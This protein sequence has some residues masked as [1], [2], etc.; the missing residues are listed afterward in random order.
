MRTIRRTLVGLLA[1]L[2][3]V[4]GLVSQAGAYLLGFTSPDEGAGLAAEAATAEGL[5]HA[6][7]GP[8]AVG[9]RRFEEAP[10]TTTAWYPA[11]HNA[12]EGAPTTYSYG[13]TVAS[14]GTSTAVASYEGVGRPTA[15]PAVARGPFPLV[16]LS[17]GFAITPGSYAWLAEHL[18]S[19]GFVVV[20]APEHEET[21]DPRNLWRSTIDRPAL[22]AQT[23]AWVEAAAGPGGELAGLVDPDTV[24][25]LG[26]SYG[27][28]TALA[29]GGARIDANA[30]AEGCDAADADDPIGFLCDALL[31]HLDQ[32]EGGEAKPP[33]PVDAVVSLAGDAAMFGERGLAH[34]TAPTMVIGGTADD[35]SP[36]EWTTSMAYDHVSSERKVEVALEGAEHFVFA[37]ECD[38]RRRLLTLID[39]GFCSDPTWE[40]ARAHA[41]I[42]HH[43]TAFLLAELGGDPMAGDELAPGQPRLYRVTRRALGY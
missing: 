14:G 34:I 10:A 2:V 30:F 24:A 22:V 4:V 23:R 42:V 8:H 21:L 5:S 32:I 9:V 20:V 38:S 36:Y 3:V 26:H 35:D 12:E 29:A 33:E 16:V 40:R 13:L 41:V 27:G 1:A 37:G 15:A 18:A 28:Y 25:V 17:S 19:H 31:P 39:G 6:A 7:P 11:V 43:V